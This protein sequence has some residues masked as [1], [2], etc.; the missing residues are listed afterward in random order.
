MKLIAALLLGVAM[1]VNAAPSLE[2]IATSTDTFAICKAADV[3][4]T[5]YVIEHGI[6]VEANPIVAPL[7]AH[8]YIPFIL[9]SYG[10]Y[11]LIKWLDNPGATL[12]A[13]VITCGVAVN[14]LLLIP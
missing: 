4:T 7:V 11:R 13:N 6:G 8:G 2:E 9:V 14:N 3:I 10:V 1:Q 5:A 12:G